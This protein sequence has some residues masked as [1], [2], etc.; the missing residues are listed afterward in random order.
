MNPKLL[1]AWKQR[2]RLHAKNRKLCT[3][4]RELY[5]K[6]DKLCAEG[7][8]HYKKGDRRYVKGL[9]LCSMSDLIWRNAV[10]AIHGNVDIQ[11]QG[12]DCIVDGVTYKKE[13]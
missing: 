11:W 7:G 6:G 2:C 12:E 5:A 4:G 1:K 3:E 13:D 9:E 10:I 8:R